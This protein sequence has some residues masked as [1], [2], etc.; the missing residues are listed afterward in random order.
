MWLSSKGCT[1][2]IPSCMSVLSMKR[3][4]IK[5][6]CTR[7]PPCQ[8]TAAAAPAGRDFHY[9][10]ASAEVTFSMW[11]SVKKGEVEN[12]EPFAETADLKIN[13]YFHYEKSCFVND[14]REILSLLP[15]NSVY[16]P[17]ADAI[18]G[19]LAGVEQIDIGL[20]P[21]NSLLW[22]FLKR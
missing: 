16:R 2:L 12:I 13:T 20:V 18:L 22:E 1:R 17:M 19:Q 10:D 4:F 6:I 7:I 5:S 21:E 9:R 8:R 11:E 14:A 3:N 15:Q